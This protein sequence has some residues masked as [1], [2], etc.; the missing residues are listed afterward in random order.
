[1]H[2]ITTFPAST[3][4][5]NTLTYTHGQPHLLLG[6]AALAAELIHLSS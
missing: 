6:W 4:V 3:V 2:S 1:M 5:I